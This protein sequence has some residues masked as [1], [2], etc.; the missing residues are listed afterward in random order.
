MTRHSE[1]SSGR[2]LYADPVVR[3]E[4]DMDRLVDLV[5][6][7]A[8]SQHRAASL[9]RAEGHASAEESPSAESLARELESKER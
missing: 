2:R 9:A 1:Y 4:P 8:E 5:L 7:L 3:G 6:H